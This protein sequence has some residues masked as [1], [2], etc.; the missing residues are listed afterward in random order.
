[1]TALSGAASTASGMGMG[2]TVPPGCD[3]EDPQIV[4]DRPEA[5]TVRMIYRGSERLH[6]RSGQRPNTAGGCRPP[7][8]RI[9]RQHRSDERHC[10]AQEDERRGSRQRRGAF[11]VCRRTS[12]PP[13]SMNARHRSCAPRATSGPRTALHCSGRRSAFRGIPPALIVAPPDVRTRAD[14]TRH[15]SRLQAPQQRCRGP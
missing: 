13:S 4:I 10:G 8:H 15:M 9:V 5:R 11:P 12:S 3:V 2:G 7:D 6:H 14:Q 1:M